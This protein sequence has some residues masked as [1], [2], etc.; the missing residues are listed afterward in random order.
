IKAQLVDGTPAPV[1]PAPSIYQTQPWAD[2]LITGI[3][4]EPA[5]TTAY[6]YK[7]INK[8]LS[9]NRKEARVKLLNGSWGFKFVNK[10]SEAPKDFFENRVK[11]WDK[12]QVPSNWEM[13]GY[14]IP[15][16]RSSRY[17]FRPVD[18]PHIPKDKN[19]VGSYQRT[20]TIP[21]SWKGMNV[22]LYFGAVSSAFK[23]WLNG[24]F[25]GYGEDSFL[26][27]E[28]NI[29][30]YLKEGENRVSVQVIRW[31]DGSYLE[32]QDQFR[33]SGIQRDV[34]LLA[35]PKVRI[36]DFHYETKLDSNYQNAKL[37]IRPKI[38]NLTGE[39]ISDSTKLKAQ[40]FDENNHPVLKNPL[41]ISVND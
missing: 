36:F 22:T 13:K 3:N 14:G 23:V 32:D 11:G 29:S 26:P 38:N 31:S 41:E 33:F 35:E 6:S 39:K 20:F 21:S 8:A 15:I 2:Q 12:I 19:P 37:A 30:P 16:Y 17:A 40:L 1:P 4:R 7:S 25:V 28:F 5:R 18:P 27:S 9:E 34:M 10:P 24:Q